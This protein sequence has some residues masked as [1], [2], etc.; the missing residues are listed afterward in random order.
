[1][2]AASPHASNEVV[3]A[4]LLVIGGKILSGRTKDQNIGYIAEYL[5]ALALISKRCGW[6]ATRRE[7]LSTH[8]MRC[9]IA[10]PMSLP[11]AGSARPT[12]TSPLIAWQRRSMCRLTPIRARS[13]S[14]T[15][16]KDDRRR[17]ERGA[18]P[19][20][21]YP[22]GRGFDPKQGVGSAR[23]TS[24]MADLMSSTAMTTEGYCPGQ[25]GFLGKKPPLIAPPGAPALRPMPRS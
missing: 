4:A 23:P 16:G 20:D 25:S 24:F 18:P 17:D 13:P 11:P 2:T 5:T 9:G 21:A 15:N 6:S 7:R 22:Q 8:S 12:E 10:T 3:T 14:C 1:M 19:H